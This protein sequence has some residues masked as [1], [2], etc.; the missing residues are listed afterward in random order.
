LQYNALVDFDFTVDFTVFTFALAAYV[1][2]T[3]N[4]I[5]NIF[6]ILINFKFPTLSFALGRFYSASRKMSATVNSDF[7]GLLVAGLYFFKPQVVSLQPSSFF[8][9]SWG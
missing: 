2:P 9:F 8:I 4:A 3:N 7:P 1:Y 5:N 6:F